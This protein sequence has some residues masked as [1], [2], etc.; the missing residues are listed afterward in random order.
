M[1]QLKWRQT[2]TPAN[3]RHQL[4]DACMNELSDDSSPQPSWP[5]ILW[6]KGR[7]SLLHSVQI[8]NP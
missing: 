2:E 4:P 6:S 8:P 1:G 5:Q 3:S 7:L